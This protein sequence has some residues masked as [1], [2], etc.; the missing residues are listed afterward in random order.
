MTISLEPPNTER[1]QSVNNFLPCI[2]DNQ[3]TIQRHQPIIELSAAYV[4]KT[5]S[6]DITTALLT[7]CA[8]GASSAL[9]GVQ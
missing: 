7:M 5:A 1:Q 8:K 2:L 3:M 6:D 9:P 4:G